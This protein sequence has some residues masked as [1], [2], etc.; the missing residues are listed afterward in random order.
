MELDAKRQKWRRR[1]SLRAA[2]MVQK[3]GRRQHL[4]AAQI[5]SSREGGIHRTAKCVQSWIFMRCMER[6]KQTQTR[7]KP[8]QFIM[9]GNF[10][11]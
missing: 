1:R 4:L 10:N 3:I 11:F 8:E 9:S 6:S 7:D 2:K 5:G